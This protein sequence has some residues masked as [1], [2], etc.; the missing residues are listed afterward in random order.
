MSPADQ[1]SSGPSH[2][3]PASPGSTAPPAAITAL[4]L[5]QFAPRCDY[6]GLAPRLAAAAAKFGID[7]TRRVGHW[8]AQISEESGGFTVL[9]EN[10]HYSAE[11]AC[12][13]WPS[14]FHDPA[15]AEACAGRP[16][17]L[18]ERVYGGR[19][20]N[21]EPG[22][23]WRYRGRGYIQITGRDGYAAASPWCGVD[24]VTYPDR[25]AEPWVAA[26]VAAGYWASRGCNALADV[27]G[28]EAI[29]HTINGALTGLEARRHALIRARS[30]W[31]F[32]PIHPGA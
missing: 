20:G 32:A 30:I 3:A 21:T 9:E 29:T 12:K 31:P 23:G 19:M 26:L 5:Q 13:T 24:L 2:A 15:A 18:A 17:A 25:A 14:R 7:T 8:L 11:H 10:L 22:D 1:P 27:D 4:R 28:I 6:T 16:V